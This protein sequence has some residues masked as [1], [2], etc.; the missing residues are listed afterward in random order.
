MALTGDI[1]TAVGAGLEQVF[2][3]GTVIY[4]AATGVHEIDNV[5]ATEYAATA[6]ETNPVG[7][8]VEKVLGLPTS[9]ELNTSMTGVDV[10]NFQ[11]GKIY[12]SSATGAHVL[13]G[14]IATEYA[15]TALQKTGGG[16]VQTALGLLTSDEAVVPGVAGPTAVHFQNGSIYQ[17]P[18]TWGARPPGGR[19]CS[20]HRRRPIDECSGASV[21]ILGCRPGTPR[22]SSS[23]ACP[24]RWS[25]SRAARSTIRPSPAHALYGPINVEFSAL[26]NEKNAAGK[27]VQ[28]VI[29]LPTGD[30]DNVTGASIMS[31]QAGTIFW[32]TATGAHA[33]YGPNAT[34]YAALAN[35]LDVD[36]HPVPDV[37]GL[38][39]RR[40]RQNQYPTDPALPGARSSSRLSHR[41][42]TC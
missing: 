16:S 26:A 20:V 41:L 8:S 24:P 39:D 38:A 13:Y 33:V 4:S 6:S 14:A 30:I 31:F 35:E 3:N 10:V 7:Q 23:A 17:S 19:R 42:R 21:Q 2:Q 1:P 32:S 12:A 5:V 29:G 40:R 25:S 11:G 22:S 34:Q 15:A 28:Q 36:G 9:N 37:S 18:S 27:V